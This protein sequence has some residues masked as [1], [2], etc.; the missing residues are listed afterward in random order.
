MLSDRF[1]RKMEK[2][3]DHSIRPLRIIAVF[4]NHHNSI[5]NVLSPRWRSFLSQWFLVEVNSFSEICRVSLETPLR[6]C[7]KWV[8]HWKETS[9]PFAMNAILSVTQSSVQWAWLFSALYEN[10]FGSK[11]SLSYPIK[12]DIFHMAI[13]W[14]LSEII[15]TISTMTNWSRSD[16][17]YNSISHAIFHPKIQFSSPLI[18]ILSKIPLQ[19]V[20]LHSPDSAIICPARRLLIWRREPIDSVN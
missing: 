7:L 13:S 8:S 12:K 18:L 11:D 4:V 15:I 14:F 2:S 1:D 5:E 19:E 9:V 6:I 16:P 20:V 10:P 17:S 3:G